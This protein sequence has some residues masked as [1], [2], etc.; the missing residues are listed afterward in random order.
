MFT[1]PTYEVVP[2]FHSIRK[3]SP[4][5]KPEVHL[6]AFGKNFNLSLKPTAG[7]LPKGNHISMWTVSRNYSSPNG[8]YYEE[9]PEVIDSLEIK[10][11]NK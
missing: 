7:L 5:I 2:V 9:V 3:R 11:E 10:Q 4:E 1:V 8:L 6:K